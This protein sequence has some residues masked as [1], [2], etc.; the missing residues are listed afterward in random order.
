LRFFSKIPDRYFQIPMLGRNTHPGHVWAVGRARLVT[1]PVPTRS[2][3]PPTMIGI[4]LV[5]C[6]AATAGSVQPTRITSTFSRTNSEASSGSRSTLP[7][8]V[9]RI[10]LCPGLSYLFVSQNFL[11]GASQAKFTRLA[12]R[13]ISSP[14]TSAKPSPRFK[15]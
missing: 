10:V 7:W 11:L 8:A 6:L 13:S 12:A 15:N 3:A 14:L 1:R 5:A 4:V 9:F 2:P